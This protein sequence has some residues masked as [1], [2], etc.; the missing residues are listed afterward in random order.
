VNAAY[1]DANQG[2]ILSSFRRTVQHLRL[3]QLGSFQSQ[4]S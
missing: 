4:A 2:A 1:A 3:R